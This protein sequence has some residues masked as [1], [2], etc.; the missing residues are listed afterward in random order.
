MGELQSNSAAFRQAL[1]KSERLRIRIVLGV[2]AAVIIL[3]TLRTLALQN[4]EDIRL[5]FIA[6]LLSIFFVGY[7]LLVLRAVRRAAEVNRDLGP[8]AWI[9]STIVEASIS[10]LAVAFLTSTVLEPAYRSSCMRTA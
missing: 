2:L 1:L 8:A 5:W 7:E 4:R 9:G 3:R 10:A 6:C